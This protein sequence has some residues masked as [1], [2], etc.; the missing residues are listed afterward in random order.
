MRKL[1]FATHNVDKIREIQYLVRER[2]KLLSLDD[3]GYKKE[4][5]EDQPT[6]EKNALQKAHFIYNLF[7]I[8]CFAD[9]TALEVEAL[10]GEPGVYSARFAEL[11]GDISKVENISDANIRKLLNMMNEKKNRK[12]RFRT[13]IALII[14]KK[15]YL[16]EGIVEGNILAERRGNY[17]FGYDPVFQPSGYDLTF[18]EMPLDEKN[19]ISHRAIAVKKL[20]KFLNEQY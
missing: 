14:N 4:I 15:E 12:A 20:V 9:D 7:E 5:P 2:Y 19:K 13:I 11:T 6:I 17:G 1:V 3:L 10:N 18:G 8:D 16:F